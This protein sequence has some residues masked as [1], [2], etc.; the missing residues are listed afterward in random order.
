LEQPIDLLV[1]QYKIMRFSNG[2]INLE[3]LDNMP[4]SE[5]EYHMLIVETAEEEKQKNI[6]ELAKK[7][8][9]GIMMGLLMNGQN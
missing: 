8:L 5:Y 3:T 2:G 1:N 4:Y 6:Q 7:G 9:P